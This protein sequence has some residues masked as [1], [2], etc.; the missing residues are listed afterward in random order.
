MMVRCPE[1]ARMVPEDT[2]Y[3]PRCGAALVMPLRLA[4]LAHLFWACPICRHE[5]ALVCR[6]PFFGEPRLA[7]RACRT[8]WRF[9]AD[10]RT[11]TAYDPAK[12][13]V[14]GA[15]PVEDLLALLPL[16]L[17][18]RPLAA[19]GLLLLPGERC[20]VRA[21]RARML[22]PRQSVQHARP[23]GRVALL[24][25]IY[26]RVAHDPLGPSPAALGTVARGPFF[27]TD[28]RAVFMGNR[29]QVEITLV[30][31][32]DVEVD[33]GYLLLHRAART[34]TFGFA[35]ESAV[36]VRAAI[37]AIQ[38]AT[39]AVPVDQDGAVAEAEAG[40]DGL[41]SAVDEIAARRALERARA[42]E[43]AARRAPYE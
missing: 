4:W 7:C 5:E 38:A 32:A 42:G 12:Q 6:Q 40:A 8:S 15:R 25:G 35:R 23:I 26:E 39:P 1:C 34:D 28:R 11:L 17:S 13:P 14:G 36:R 41:D 20:L 33:E 31:L 30:R 37:L 27:V 29:R 18:G 19:P 10:A 21:D 43:A 16:P 22:A 3:C 9:D 24:P 2:G